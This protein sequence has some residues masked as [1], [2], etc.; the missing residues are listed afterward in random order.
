MNVMVKTLL[1]CFFMPHNV[2]T[3]F[4]NLHTTPVIIEVLDKIVQLI[5]AST[6]YRLHE[7]FSIITFSWPSEESLHTSYLHCCCWRLMLH[8]RRW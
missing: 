7:K 2:L 6:L 1:V 3:V 8:C 5:F 4:V